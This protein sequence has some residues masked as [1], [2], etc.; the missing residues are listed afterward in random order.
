MAQLGNSIV[1]SRVQEC[2]KRERVD[3]LLFRG[4]INNGQFSGTAYLFKARCG[5]ADIDANVLH[6]PWARARP[7]ASGLWAFHPS[8]LNLDMS[9]SFRSYSRH[10]R[11]M[12]SGE[13]ATDLA[14]SGHAPLYPT[15]KPIYTDGLD[16]YRF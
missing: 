3:T 12:P 6:P 9:S 1:K 11:M 14:G 16:C 2:W 4:Q 10:T 15:V 13:A 8:A 7:M 5:Q